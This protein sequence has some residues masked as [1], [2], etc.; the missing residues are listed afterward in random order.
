ML[1]KR[2]SPG[3]HNQI[4]EVLDRHSIPEF[5]LKAFEKRKLNDPSNTAP[6]WHVRF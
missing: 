4:E 6:E 5:L 1:V 2:N 3:T